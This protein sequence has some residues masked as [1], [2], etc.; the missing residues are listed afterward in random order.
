MIDLFHVIQ[1]FVANMR[2][3]PTYNQGLA[4]RAVWLSTLEVQP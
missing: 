4:A 3:H 1:G 2:Q